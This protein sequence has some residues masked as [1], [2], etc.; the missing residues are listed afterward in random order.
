VPK[1]KREPVEDIPI[2]VN[3]IKIDVKTVKEVKEE[4]K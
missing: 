1:V 4:K 2:K 3:T